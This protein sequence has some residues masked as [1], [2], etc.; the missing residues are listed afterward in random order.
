MLKQ[1]F[2]HEQVFLGFFLNT[3]PYRPNLQVFETK[4]ESVFFCFCFL[5]GGGGGGGGGG[6]C[7]ES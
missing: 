6:P 5:R 1:Q 4:W 3:A 7:N 2:A